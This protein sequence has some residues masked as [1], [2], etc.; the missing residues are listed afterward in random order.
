MGKKALMVA[1]SNMHL[2]AK[3]CFISDEPSAYHT[4]FERADRACLCK[5]CMGPASAPYLVR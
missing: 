1:L 2:S 3:N 4:A 5:S